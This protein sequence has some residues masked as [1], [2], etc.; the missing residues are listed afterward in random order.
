MPQA[1]EPVKAQAPRCH[2]QALTGPRPCSE[3]SEQ[4]CAP[5]PCG[6]RP[7]LILEVPPCIALWLSAS[8]ILRPCAGLSAPGAASASASPAPSVL[9]LLLRL[10]QAQ[11]VPAWP[12]IW[13]R[14]VFAPSAGRS[15]ASSNVRP[16]EGEKKRA[17]RA[18]LPWLDTIRNNCEP[19][20]ARKR[21]D[22]A[23]KR[24]I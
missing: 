8:L 10:M 19:V 22:G 12:A 15:F 16:A 7:I 3:T 23:G 14:P 9:C 17:A 4:G 6:A 18:A 20:T 13:L 2:R 24:R 21:S 1:R 11:S 5:P